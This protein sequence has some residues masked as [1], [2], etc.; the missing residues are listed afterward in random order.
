MLVVLL[1]RLEQTLEDAE[2]KRDR[3]PNT[4]GRP[5]QGTHPTGEDQTTSIRLSD[6]RGCSLPFSS[7]PDRPRHRRLIPRPAG[8]TLECGP[9][10]T[11]KDMSS[12]TRRHEL[13][14]AE[15]AAAANVSA[16]T[17]RYYER[18]G[19]LP[20]PARSPAGYRL[21]DPVTVE[22]LRFIQGCQRLGL[23]LRDITDLLAVRDTG[24]CPCEPAADLLQ[25]RLAELD[26]DMARLTALR[27][28]ITAMA[29][30][31]PAPDCPPPA[32]GTAWCPPDEGR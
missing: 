8:L 10:F 14:V 15:L 23:K 12:T 17:I 26:A 16:D 20:E 25:R 18:A 5:T 31:L 30:A 29:D 24:T 7:M 27:L 13:R 19:L 11:V 22:R 21:Y 6:P 9:R 1:G 3:R 2:P 28:E 32:P 4:L